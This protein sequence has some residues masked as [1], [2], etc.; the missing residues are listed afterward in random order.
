MNWVAMFPGQGSQ[1]AGM[2]EELLNLYP[3][4]LIDEFEETLGWSLKQIILQS[5][6][7]EITK[8]NIAQP[9]IFAISYCYGLEAFKKLGQP[10]IGI[11]HSLGE[12]TAL[13]LAEFIS[14]RDALRIIS[15]RGDSMQKAVENSNSTMAAV[16]T[17]DLRQTIDS[18]HALNNQGISINISNFNDGSQIVIG[19]LKDDINYL[20]SNPVDLNAKRVIP[21]DV[22][23]A[24]HSEFVSSA[25]KEVQNIVDEVEFSEGKF[26][27]YMN[28][29]AKVADLTTIKQRLVDQIDNSVMFYDQILNIK[30]FAKPEKWYHI[31]PGNVT[32]GMVKKSISSEDIEIINSLDSLNNI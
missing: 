30:N 16:L 5:D 2:G 15:V 3:D 31:G 11:G 21:L 26:D 23:G 29:D 27:V 6:Q 32:A 19:G 9:Y 8:T 24:F 22:A 12:Y 28:V 18:V 25:K 13:A 1:K 17:S 10:K 7:S 4:L 14:Y 20:K